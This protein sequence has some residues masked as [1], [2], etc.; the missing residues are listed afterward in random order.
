[1]AQPAFKAITIYGSSIGNSSEWRIK[2][3]IIMKIAP[4]N[5]IHD[6]EVTFRTNL[7]ISFILSPSTL[8]E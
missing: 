2:E 1:M 7:N 3:K 6:Q 5:A 4:F 8:F